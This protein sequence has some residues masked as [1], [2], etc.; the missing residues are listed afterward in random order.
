[1]SS[2]FPHDFLAQ[3]NIKLIVYGDQHN[4]VSPR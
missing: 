1:L 3:E 2:D 4:L